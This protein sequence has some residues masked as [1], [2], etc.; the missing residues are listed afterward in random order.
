VIRL[1]HGLLSRL[2]SIFPTEPAT[3]QVA[4]QY[5]ELNG[6]YATVSRVIFEG[7]EA[8]DK[9]ATASVSSLFG[10]L[11]LLKAACISNVCYVDRLISLFMRVLQRITRDHLTPQQTAQPGA[12]DSSPVANELLVISLDLLKGRVGVM[13]VEMRKSFI[14][15]VL[16]GLIEKTPDPKVMRAIIKMMEEWMKSRDPQVINQGPSLREKSILLVKLMQYVEKRFPDDA[17]LN[18]NFLEIVN[19]IYR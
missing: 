4:S 15:A 6:L 9:N 3:S 18:G 2:M 11:M 10:T 7:L 12:G 13:G 17:D 19:F 5:E 14:G 16:V 1:V 8:F